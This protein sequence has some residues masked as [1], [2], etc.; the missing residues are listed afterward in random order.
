MTTKMNCVCDH[1]NS[2]LKKSFHLRGKLVDKFRL[3]QAFQAAYYRL[4]EYQSRYSKPL[5]RFFLHILAECGVTVK[6]CKL[7]NYSSWG[8]C[9]RL[10][11]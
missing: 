5:T 8:H 1:I 9:T 10:I 7:C 4:S 3:Y 11:K 6:L 2:C